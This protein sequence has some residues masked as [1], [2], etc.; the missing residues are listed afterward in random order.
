MKRTILNTRAS[1]RFLSTWFRY[2][3]TLPTQFLFNP[4]FRGTSLHGLLSR[5]RRH[6]PFTRPRGRTGGCLAL[7]GCRPFLNRRPL[8]S[9]FALRAERSPT[10]CAGHH[11]R[12]P[13]FARAGSLCRLPSSSLFWAG[14]LCPS[15]G[16]FRLHPPGDRLPTNP[17]RLTPLR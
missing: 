16:F 5:S 9:R 12:S 14:G 2:T 1:R 13:T 7:N 4:A 6:G 3:L 17:C 15:E 11:P 8:N 10:G